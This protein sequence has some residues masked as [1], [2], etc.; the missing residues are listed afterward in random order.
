MSAALAAADA[1]ADV[2]L[3]E[4][5]ETLGGLT[6][7]IERNGLVFDNGQHVFL[8]C[9]TSY[10][11]FLERIGARE[12]V[13]LQRRLDVPVLS[14]SGTRSSLRRHRL[15]APLHLGWALATYRHLGARDRV[16]LV[17][18]ALALRA[19]DVD[20]PRLDQ[21]TFESW[22]REHGQSPAAIAGLWD[23]I[24]LPTVNLH[25]SESSLAL[26]TKVFREG[27]LDHADS[28]DVGWSRV[29]LATLH[30]VHGARALDAVGVAVR[31]G[32]SVREIEPSSSRGIVVHLADGEVALD[33]VVVA[34]P[35]ATAAALGVADAVGPASRLGSSPIVNIHLV[36]DRQVC[37]LEMFA[38]IDSPVQFVFDRTASSGL[39]AGQCLAL[40]LSAA[41]SY[42]SQGSG[43]LVEFFADALQS[44]L[45]EARS[46]RLV[47][48][49][50]T[51][52]RAATFRGVPGSS[53]WRPAAVTST[54]GVFLAGAWCAT[55]WPATMEGAV[56]SGDDAAR[57]ALAWL[58]GRPARAAVSLGARP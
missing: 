38:A 28:G 6:S 40:S 10:L 55:G 46:E 50:V 15:P 52:E 4:R 26:A 31:A 53:A 39:Q 30:G 9:C 47:E 17:R 45:P 35:P 16:G 22:L 42:M 32:E 51:R 27:L 29:P 56:R 54:P 20:D 37:D 43:Q 24:T 11:D 49:Q 41:S 13:H 57:Q 8:R 19:L 21:S 5:R 36:Y 23:L 25:A 3:F 18:A 34:T 2:V 12:L 44:L 33:A 14:P 48:S 58:E 7:S 1:G